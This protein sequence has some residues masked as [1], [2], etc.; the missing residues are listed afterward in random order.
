MEVPPYENINQLEREENEYS[1]DI[2]CVCA[3]GEKRK[4][5]QT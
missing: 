4:K 3:E 2:I 5:M 1:R